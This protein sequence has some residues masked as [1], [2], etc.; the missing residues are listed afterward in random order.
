MILKYIS[1]LCFYLIFYTHLVGDFYCQIGTI[2]PKERR[3]DWS[4]AGYSSS[5]L[6][7]FPEP[8]SILYVAEPDSNPAVNYKNIQDKLNEA[9]LKNCLT[10]VR[11]NEGVYIFNSPITLTN[12]YSNIIIRGAGIDKTTL[13]FLAGSKKSGIYGFRAE[14]T[15]IKLP[16]QYEILNYDKKSKTLSLSDKL[17]IIKPGYYFD[18][19]TENGS[20]LDSPNSGTNPAKNFLGQVVKVIEVSNDSSTFELA[21]DINVFWDIA[22]KEATTKYIEIFNPVQNIGFFDFKIESDNVN[23]GLGSNFIF[24]YA[25]NCWVEGVESFNPPQVHFDIDRSS[26][27]IIKDSYI[28]HAQDYGKIPGAGYGVHI[29]SRSTNCLIENNIFEH[30]RH[31]L[32]VS[33]SANRNVFGYNFSTDQYS[34]PFKNLSDLNIHGYYPFANLFEGNIVE[35]IQAD[36]YWG[37]NGPFNTF[38]RNFITKEYFKLENCDYANLLMNSCDVS[39]E[40]S[41]FILNKNANSESQSDTSFYYKQ[42]PEF[43]ES[44]NWPLLKNDLQKR[45]DDLF[46]RKR[47]V[48]P[49]N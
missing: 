43:L 12:K 7:S 14:G 8:K 2:I 9:S 44:Y 37:S 36:N 10:E 25:A 34:F 20:W 31:S 18:I 6:N 33:L 38:I 17:S 32:V 29:H 4:T 15:I 23:N 1:I 11:L 49:D 30:L 48:L 28:H 21:D 35:R 45:Q 3:V 16:H 39:T 40:N 13:K 5:P 19:R 47:N 26:S 42:K 41:K 22:S 24:R 27:I 46:P